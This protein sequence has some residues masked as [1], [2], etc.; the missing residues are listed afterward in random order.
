MN[1]PQSKTFRAFNLISCCQSNNVNSKLL[2]GL[3]SSWSTQ[4]LA[5]KSL[6]MPKYFDHYN[7]KRSENI[8]NS[9]TKLLL[10]LI[11]L[12]FNI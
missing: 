10:T 12:F 2:S 5:A 1:F 11:C 9:L 7:L 6:K 8:Y 3:F 4:N